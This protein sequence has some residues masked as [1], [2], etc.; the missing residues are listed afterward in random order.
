M[1]G[2]SL[3]S[4]LLLKVQ[5]KVTLVGLASTSQTK[6]MVSCLRAPCT[7]SG[8]L[9]GGGVAFWCLQPPPEFSTYLQTGATAAQ[10][11]DFGTLLRIPGRSPREQYNRGTRSERQKKGGGRKAQNRIYNEI[12]TKEY[13]TRLY[14]MQLRVLSR[15]LRKDNGCA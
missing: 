6:L 1:D 12:N 14:K 15:C 8:T 5:W 13:I 11:M 3:R 7:S 9:N 2:T 10:R 4:P